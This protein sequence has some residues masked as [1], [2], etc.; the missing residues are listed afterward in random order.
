M[1]VVAFFLAQFGKS[2][3]RSCGGAGLRRRPATSLS[4]VD[5][6]P[7]DQLLAN[8]VDMFA[9]HLSIPSHDDLAF[10]EFLR[11]GGTLYLDQCGGGLD[12][13]VAIR[14]CREDRN[15][16]S[17]RFPAPEFFSDPLIECDQGAA[18]SGKGKII[19]AYNHVVL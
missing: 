19:A 2:T 14:Q 7:T 12:G 1:R 16:W 8:R 17:A 18:A 15:L 3:S 11:F 9:I 10:E 5:P 6:C 4:S 13:A